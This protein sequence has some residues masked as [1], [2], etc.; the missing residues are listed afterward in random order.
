MCGMVRGVVRFGVI[1]AIVGG[2]VILLAGPGRVR[3]LIHQARSTIN[4]SIDSAIDD[5]IAL[6]ERVKS[7]EAEY[8]KRIAAVQRDLDEV[9][10]NVSQL[11]RELAINDRVVQLA[12]GD[13]QNF[14]TLLSR[15]SQ[16]ESG[17]G[18]VRVRYEDRLMTTRE[19]YAQANV[20]STMR[21]SYKSRAGDLRQELAVL[22]QQESRLDQLLTQLQTEQADFQAQLWQLDRQVD[23]VARNDRLI[24]IMK[25]RQD[26][27]DE[28][29]RYEATSLDSLHRQL[30]S[31][32]SAQEAELDRLAGNATHQTYETRAQFEIDNGAGS[33]DSAPIELEQRVIELDPVRHSPLANR[34]H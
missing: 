28:H 29:S 21:D 34:G 11:N 2:G 26:R 9:R 5:P 17:G 12:E 13:L 22:N 16:Q 33:E 31:R 6:R 19:A 20:I 1:A 18:V 30:A 23:A 32:R 25:K 8:P 27:I 4:A 7:L 24:A 10:A 3:A 15:A 14:E